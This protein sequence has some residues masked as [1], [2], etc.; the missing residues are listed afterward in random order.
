M[1]D[2][3]QPRPHRE[4]AL[5]GLERRERAHHCALQCILGVVLVA[6]DRAAVAVQRLMMAVVEHRECAR[7]APRH[8]PREQLVAR[9]PAAEPKL[10]PASHWKRKIAHRSHIGNAADS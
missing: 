4:V 2:P 3:E 6:N 9:Q 7:A 10:R 1:N 5:A 8:E